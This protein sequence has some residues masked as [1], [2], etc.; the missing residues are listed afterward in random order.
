MGHWQLALL[1]RV[2]LSKL[3]LCL[4]F[5]RIVQLGTFM[6]SN[7][8]PHLGMTRTLWRPS[9]TIDSLPALGCSVRWQVQGLAADLVRYW[10]MRTLQRAMLLPDL[11]QKLNVCL[12]SCRSVFWATSIATNRVTLLGKS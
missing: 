12:L 6:A 9:T 2:S 3:S 10:V 1:L 5:C 7:C 4:L 11:L 8:V